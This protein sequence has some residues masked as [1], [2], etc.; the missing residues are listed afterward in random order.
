MRVRRRPELSG[1]TPE[2]TRTEARDE[3]Q[4]PSNRIVR[5]RTIRGQLARILALSLTLVLALLGITIAREID[6]FRRSGDTVRAVSLALAVQ[7][8]VQEAQRERGLSNGLLGG[9]TRLQQPVAEQ[10]ARTDRSLGLLDDALAGGPPGVAQVHS[11][12]GQFGALAATRTQVDTRRTTRQAAFQFYTDGIAALNRLALG[13]DQADDPQVRHGLQALYALGDAKEH[14]AKE[15]GFLN[16][17]FAADEFGPGEYV[18]FLD[19]RAAKAAGLAA[20][21]RDATA[22][23][24]AFLEAA[25]RSENATRAMES[26]NIA[27]ASSMGPLV[28][29][30]DPITWWAQM[31]GVID[32]Q[33][34]VQQAVGDNVRQR[35]AVLRK[36]AALTLGGFLLAAL[37]AILAEVMLVITSIRAIVRPLGTLAA[38]ADEVATRRLPDVIAAWQV[39]GD[40]SPDPPPPVRTPRGATIEI[41]A[42]AGALDRV[43]STAFELASEQALV[44]RNTTESMAN[45]ARRNQNLV[46]RQLGLISEFEREELDPK[47]LSNLFEL[48][49]LATRMRRNAESLLVLVGEVSPR[50]WAEPIPLTDVIRAGLSEVDDYRRVVLRRV[51]DIAITGAVVSELAHMLAELI[52]NG[53]AFS[54]PDLEVEIY[55]RK[56]PGGYLLA[57]VDHGVGMPVPQLAAANARLRGEQDFV[58]A[59]TRY[60]G[61]YVVGRL[62]QRLGIDVELIVSPVSGIVARL[63][64]PANILAGDRDRHPAPP[65]GR[66]V[67]EPAASEQ[68]TVATSA[69]VNMISR[70]GSARDTDRRTLTG[71]VGSRTPGMTGPAQPRAG[72]GSP[73]PAPAPFTHLLSAS[74][75]SVV[76][77]SMPGLPAANGSAAGIA[78]SSGDAATNGHAQDGLEAGAPAD[79]LPA[80][81]QSMRVIPETGDTSVESGEPP[82]E[83]AGVRRTRNGLVKR[84]K[85]TR[86]SETTGGAPRSGSGQPSAPMTERSPDEVRGM[87]SSFRAGH[88]RGGPDS[89]HSASPHAHVAG[90]PDTDTRATDLVQTSGF[91]TTT[92]EEIR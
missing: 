58:V 47:A 50:R 26:E 92:A 60:L 22:A 88:Q 13:L 87:L 37:L 21:A 15:R 16:G 55:G 45:L 61:H 54:P 81:E 9:D 82:V 68:V 5:P 23:E 7:D 66:T 42:V 31:S 73:T 12:V 10:R 64:L 44:R 75:A 70:S 79:L 51:D 65:A 85:R 6:A 48:D 84:N 29:S 38:E 57:V 77:E 89:A 71:S 33:R 34:A 39:S 41:A 90:S 28:R 3:R 56:L 49:H 91:A 1:G 8:V 69:Q 35:A 52:E 40:T 11:A 17:V 80:S 63:L 27:I 53:L 36:N 46:R 59:P 86:A 30:L 4:V 76:H 14:T 43:Q 78:G 24:Q 62:A 74:D 67:A 83:V 18:Q 20:F 2:L 25:M 19:I 72:S 32:E